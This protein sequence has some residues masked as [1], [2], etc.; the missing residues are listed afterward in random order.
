MCVWVG[1]W[2]GGKEVE[3]RRACVGGDRRGCPNPKPINFRLPWHIHTQ[4]ENVGV[5][6]FDYPVL[7]AADILLYQVCRWITIQ[8]IA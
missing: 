2:S 7:M 8:S 5:G 4:G 1:G 6:L 3:K